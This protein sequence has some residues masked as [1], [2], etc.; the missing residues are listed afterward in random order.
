[1]FLLLVT[2]LIAAPLELLSVCTKTPVVQWVLQRGGGF[3]WAPAPWELSTQKAVS[4]SREWVEG[5]IER[6]VDGGVGEW[7]DGGVEVWMD[8]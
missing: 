5:W 1:M 2:V 7:V 3:L 6:W 8:G 4:A